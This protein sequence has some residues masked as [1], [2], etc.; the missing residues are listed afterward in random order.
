MQ[1]YIY[2][3]RLIQRFKYRKYPGDPSSSQRQLVTPFQIASA[4]IDCNSPYNGSVLQR[5]SFS[6]V[7]IAQYRLEEF[8]K[9]AG[10]AC[11]RLSDFRH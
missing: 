10:A 6:S 3:L 5:Q 2:G 1:V 11:Q 4:G 9:S 8:A 7:N